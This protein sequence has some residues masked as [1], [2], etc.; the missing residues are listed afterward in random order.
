MFYKR[1]I[2]WKQGLHQRTE[3][4]RVYKFLWAILASFSLLGLISDPQISSKLQNGINVPKGLENKPKLVSIYSAQAKLSS[5][6]IVRRRQ[7]FGFNIVSV[8]STLQYVNIKWI[9]LLLYQGQKLV[10]KY[11]VSAVLK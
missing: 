3:N 8:C 10:R 1:F 5:P 9:I 2:H 11:K 4:Y 7:C 6:Y